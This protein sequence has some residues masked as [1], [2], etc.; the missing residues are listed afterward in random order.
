MFLADG[1]LADQRKTA[2]TK[3]F[4]GYPGG[5]DS[6]D[7]SSSSPRLLRL[8]SRSFQRI[9][10]AQLKHHYHQSKAS[11]NVTESAHAQ[12]RMARLRH[13]RAAKRHLAAR[14]DRAQKP[15][16][17]QHCRSFHHRKRHCAKASAT[18]ATLKLS[19]CIV[20]A[21]AIAGL[22]IYRQLICRRHY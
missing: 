20:A 21:L 7:I 2:A 5:S 3:N 22:N 15:Q 17:A 9:V 18:G 1:S 4:P 12:K 6:N 13:K 10:C 16:L 14:D 11:G 8:Q 19:A